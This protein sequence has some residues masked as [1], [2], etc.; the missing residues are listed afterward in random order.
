[1]RSKPLGVNLVPRS[2]CGAIATS[3]AKRLLA[4]RDLFDAGG[5]R[6]R[7][8]LGW[9]L[10]LRFRP[11]DVGKAANFGSK[12]AQQKAGFEHNDSRGFC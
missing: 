11:I 10:R 9:G 12:L 5:A 6:Y 7:V 8:R 1:M 4:G 3:A 2:D